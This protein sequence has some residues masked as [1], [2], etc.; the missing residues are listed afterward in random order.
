MPMTLLPHPRGK[1]RPMRSWRDRLTRPAGEEGFTLLETVVALGIAAT[2]LL[3]LLGSSIFALQATVGA[4]QNQQAGDYLNRA[5]EQVRSLDYGGVAMV[6]S[7]LTGD[8]RVTLSGGVYRYDAGAGAEVVDARSAGAITPHLAESAT[9]NGVY[10]VRRYITIPTGTTVNAQGIPALRRLTVEVS[11]RHSGRERTRRSSTILTDTRRGLPLPNYTW[12]AHGSPVA[13]GKNPGNDLSYGFALTNL[14][15]RDSW[16]IAATTAGWTY[17]VDTDRDGT[18]SEDASEPPLASATTALIEPG[19]ALPFYVVAHR[20]I[21]GGENGTTTTVFS[22]RSVSQPSVAAKTVATT[23]AVS[24]GAVTPPSA[25]PTPGPSV[26]PSAAPPGPPCTPGTNTG[27]ASVAADPA[28]LSKPN[29]SYSFLPMVLLNGTTSGDTTTQPSN[30]MSTS[31]GGLQAQLCNWSTEAGANLAGRAVTG[32]VLGI[33]GQAV[34][35]YQP[36]ATKGA[37]IGGTAGMSLLVQCPVGGIP[38]LTVRLSRGSLP[39][40][41]LGVGTVII[42]ISCN[43]GGFVRADVMIPIPIATTVAK[44]DTLVATLT[45]T[46]TVRLAYGTTAAN[47]RLTIGVK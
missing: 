7:D 16:L 38:T 31:T 33:L 47:A 6:T 25:S 35:T 20:V 26:S 24:A 17:Y 30:T 4:R 1:E 14:G 28:G 10:T 13:Q 41:T 42:P 22:A 43:A 21:G 32:G 8:P 36:T 9:P 46:S 37:L 40:V 3:G 34:W 15:A 11:W 2:A 44:T 18:W 5:V 19:Q 45:S 27:T 12:T 39:L 29:G 23:L